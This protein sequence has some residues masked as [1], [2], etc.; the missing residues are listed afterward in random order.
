[1]HHTFFRI[2]LLGAVVLSVS[3]CATANRYPDLKAD[4]K[5]MVRQAT[6]QTRGETRAG[7]RGYEASNPTQFQNT[8]IFG[9]QTQGLVSFYP[10]LN[11]TRWILPIEN[12]ILSP[13]AIHDE[14]LYFGGGDGY[15]YAVDA[16]TGRVQWR[17]LVRNPLVSK[18]TFS[19]G[20]LFVTSSDDTVYAFDAGTGEWL[21]HYRRR[22]AEDATIFGASAPLVVDQELLVG[23]SDGFLVGLSIHDGTLL[24]QERLHPGSKFT[25]VDAPPVLDGD[26]IYISS[27]D[28]ALYALSRDDK[29]VV[30]RFDSG[31]SR[32]VEVEGNRLF[33][34]SSSGRVYALQKES[35]RVIWEFDLD[36]GTPTDLV[37]TD[38]YVIFGSSYQ[39]L[40]VLNKQT[41]KPLYRYHVGS[42]SGFTGAPFY[43]PETRILY[44]LS[45]GG[46]LYSFLLRDPDSRERL[47]T[48][49]TDPYVF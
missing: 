11:Q 28:G 48:K 45:Q 35:S 23:L 7:D 39:Y 44:I 13:I 46:N 49:L 22:S 15:V 27:Y 5:I 14:T 1:M 47:S 37:I 9:N 4:P 31:G 21:W 40:Y 41:G 43:V 36:S 10:T 12:G 19:D 32:K 18:P 17:Y 30:W 25:D 34:P 38:E 3:A 33:F 6:L 29:E 8:L 42:G 26:R 2:F 20:R 24:W 16:N